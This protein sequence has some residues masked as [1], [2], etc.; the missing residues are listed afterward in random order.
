MSGQK[1]L[2]ILS[3]SPQAVPGIELAKSMGLHVVVSDMNPQAPGF[4][5]ADDA[6][7]ASTYD[8]AASVAAARRYHRHVRPIDGVICVASDVPHTVAAIAAALD[9]PGIPVEVAR[10]AI[11]KFAMKE[12]FRADGVAIPRYWPVASAAALKALVATQGYPLVV[13]PVDSR[14]S[15][16]VSLLSVG[17]D[18]EWAYGEA[19]RHSPSARVMA[20][21]FM[22]GP[23]VS[24]ESIILDGRAYTPGFSDRNYELMARYAPYFIED[25]GSLPSHLDEGVQRAVC[26]LVERAAASLGVV[27]GVVKGDIVVTEGRPYVIEL[28]ARLSGGYFCTH[29]IPL[30]TGVNIVRAVIELALGEA[31]DPQ[32]LVPTFMRPVAQRYI[33]PRPGRVV[34]IG[35]LARV[36]QMRGVEEVV[37]ESRVGDICPPPTNGPCR[38]GMVI[39]TGETVAEAVANAEAAVEAVQIETEPER[40]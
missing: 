21:Q 16:G 13:K 7:I 10:R 37:V 1:T 8:V 3:G 25:G 19:R 31:V 20:E 38:A 17:G 24:T 36:R 15:R 35:D 2:L 39:A 28:A 32:T 26:E 40:G 33:F 30:N 4:E 18:A 14:G 29:E 12:R 11:D 22:P 5:L 34:A 27:N 9:L 23:Q 6:L